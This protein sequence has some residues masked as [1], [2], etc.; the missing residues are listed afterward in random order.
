MIRTRR[1][2]IM[3]PRWIPASDKAAAH[4]FLART[5]GKSRLFPPTAR[6]VET[7]PWSFWQPPEIPRSSAMAMV[8]P[9]EW[10]GYGSGNVQHGTSCPGTFEE[11]LALETGKVEI[12]PSE[13]D[14]ETFLNAP[15]LQS[16]MEDYAKLVLTV[17]A[18]LG[19]EGEGIGGGG[20]AGP[21]REIPPGPSGILPQLH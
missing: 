2:K 16:L 10:Q 15:A 5:R 19:F 1:L 4:P 11:L 14:L 6:D 13:W 12:D 9:N 8:A 18:I 3:T 7:L 20:L 17:T 21:V